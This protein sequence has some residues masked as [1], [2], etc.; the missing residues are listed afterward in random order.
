[1]I[2]RTQILYSSLAVAESAWLFA[3]TSIVGVLIGQGGS[4]LPWLV[5]LGVLALSMAV[6]WVAG[7]VGGDFIALALLQGAVGLTTVYTAVA[8][9]STA[10]S[11]GFDGFWFGRLLLGEFGSE[12]IVAIVVSFV[13]AIALWMRGVRF[14]VLGEP[15][16]TLHTSFRIGIAAIAFAMIIQVASDGGTGVVLVIF[17]FFAASLGGM[18][19]GRL[20]EEGAWAPAQR[21]WGR[22]IALSIGAVL[23]VGVLLGVL[24]AAYGSGPLGVIV[25]VAAAVRDALLKVMEVVL[26]PPLTVLFWIIEWLLD[27]F[28]SGE[29]RGQLLGNLGPPAAAEEPVGEMMESAGDS[30]IENIL[31]VLV[32]PV[33]FILLLF[34]FWILMKSFQRIRSRH[35]EEPDADRESIRGDADTRADLAEL[36]GRLIPGFLKRDGGEEAGLRF[37]EGEPGITEVFQLYFRCLSAGMRRG[38]TLESH[39]TPA[40]LAGTLGAA[41]PGAPVEQ[42]TRRFEAA[43]YGHEPTNSELLGRLEAGLASVEES[44]PSA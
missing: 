43:C 22:V 10:G 2:N 30:L 7:G 33:G 14:I 36:F 44:Q 3:L 26:T 41:L 29:E 16:E 9:R 34:V 37:P 39:M 27:R 31:E 42:I 18:S 28:G 15:W 21:I 24:G 32:W 12:E 20:A 40:E 8:L 11:P 4:P 13:I 23:A 1:M 19:V 6:T 38:A 35:K 17:P 5:I 25:D